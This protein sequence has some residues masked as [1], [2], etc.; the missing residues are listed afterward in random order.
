MLAD[1]PGILLCPAI[2]DLTS[3]VGQPQAD[4][5]TFLSR[6]F[7]QVQ[8]DAKHQSFRDEIVALAN[9]AAALSAQQAIRLTAWAQCI[10][11]TIKTQSFGTAINMHRRGPLSGLSLTPWRSV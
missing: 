10:S 8:S 1:M 2:L 7:I 4:V 6:Q 5:P 11:R 3:V 9:D